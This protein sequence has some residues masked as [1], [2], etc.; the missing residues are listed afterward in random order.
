ML[1]EF[2]LDPED[3]KQLQTMKILDNW[4]I[5]LAFS[6]NDK[7]IPHHVLEDLI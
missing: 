1:H 6:D 3:F 2:M 4:L 7:Y 5:K